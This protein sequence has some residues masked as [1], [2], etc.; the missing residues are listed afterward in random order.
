M[1][2]S[3]LD[4]LG[5]IKVSIV[6]KNYY[7]FKREEVFITVNSW[8]VDRFFRSK[9][10]DLSQRIENVYQSQYALFSAFSIA[11]TKLEERYW[12]TVSLN[13]EGN[14]TLI[15]VCD[16][17]NKSKILFQ[18]VSTNK[19]DAVFSAYMFMAASKIKK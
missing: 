8:A 9:K 3:V 13:A 16:K 1:L 11:L 18:K 19:Y 17:N 7:L 15:V 14:K 5:I 4:D 6:P 12:V 10:I 2:K